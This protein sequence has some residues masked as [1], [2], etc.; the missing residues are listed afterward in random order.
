MARRNRRQLEIEKQ[1]K[2]RMQWIT[3]VILSAFILLGIFRWGVVGTF[4]YSLQRFLFG[5]LYWLILLAVIVCIAMRI[6]ERENRKGFA[7]PVPYI[8]FCTSV[9]LICS[10]I[11]IDPEMTGGAPAPRRPD[12]PAVGMGDAHGLYRGGAASDARL[13]GSG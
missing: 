9:L 4:L 1:K 2:E 11:D 7:S 8:L 3:I 12:P 10:W 6:R 5:D 13:P